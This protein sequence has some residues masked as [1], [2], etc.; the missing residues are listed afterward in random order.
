MSSSSGFANPI[1]K[2]KSRKVGIVFILCCFFKLCL[3]SPA[4]TAAFL[5]YRA[6]L[7]CSG[8]DKS[9]GLVTVTLLF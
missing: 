2:K 3:Q 5:V 6:Y 9:L 4:E 1:R 8:N 7:K